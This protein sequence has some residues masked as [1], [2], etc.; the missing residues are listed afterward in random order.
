MISFQCFDAVDLLTGRVSIRTV[1]NP[2]SELL[3][4]R[5]AKQKVR[6]VYAHVE[7]YKALQTITELRSVTCRMGSH[8]VTCHP[9]QVNEPGLNLSQAGQYLIYLPRRDGRLS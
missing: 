4:E 3:H 6:R 8:S 2:K 7:I 5:L 9:R 1:G